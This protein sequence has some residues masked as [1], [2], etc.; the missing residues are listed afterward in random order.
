MDAETGWRTRALLIR[1]GLLDR[2]ASGPPPPDAL[3]AEEAGATEACL[4]AP[5]CPQRAAALAFQPGPGWTEV[6]RY[7]PPR[8]LLGVWLRGIGAAELMPPDILR[9]IEQPGRAL[10]VYRTPML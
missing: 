6:A 2:V 9:K 5:A 10:V 7:D 8:R 4:R 1:P 3:V